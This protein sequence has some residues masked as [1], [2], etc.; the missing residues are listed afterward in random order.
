VN[1]RLDKIWFHQAV[2]FDFTADLTGTGNRSLLVLLGWVQIFPLVVGWVGSHKMD[3]WT[4]LLTAGRPAY[5]HTRNNAVLYIY[6]VRR[7]STEAFAVSSANAN[8]Q[9]SRISILRFFSDFKKRDFLR[10]FRNGVR[11]SK[12]AVSKSFVL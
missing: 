2:K 3:P 12:K 6:T 4:T 10:F 8:T 1:S 11:K 9:C 5:R 7:F